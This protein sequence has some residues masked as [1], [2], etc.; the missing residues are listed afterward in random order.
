MKQMIGCIGMIHS[1]QITL[2]IYLHPIGYQVIK[3]LFIWHQH[4]H[5]CVGESI[6]SFIYNDRIVD[7]YLVCPSYPANILTH[8]K[9]Y[10]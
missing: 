2:M 4:L 10:R 5:F 6:S 1:M 8:T 3:L 9:L 7:G